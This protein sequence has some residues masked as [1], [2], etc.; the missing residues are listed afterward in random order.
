MSQEHLQILQ[1]PSRRHD[2]P[3]DPRQRQVACCGCGCAASPHVRPGLEAA[4]TAAHQSGRGAA[5]LH[6]SRAAGWSLPAPALLHRARQLIFWPASQM[7]AGSMRDTI[8]QVMPAET[9]CHGTWEFL[10][11][12]ADREAAPVQRSR[13]SISVSS[14]DSNLSTASWLPVPWEPSSLRPG[15]CMPRQCIEQYGECSHAMA[16]LSGRQRSS[17]PT[18]ILPQLACKSD[19]LNTG[20][21]MTCRQW[22]C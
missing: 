7:M 18:L 5:G 6:L 3:A 1:R 15:S 4:H 17:Q 13:P 19:W 14:T 22:Q 2:L 10:R 21:C 12:M 20:F 9:D 8:S 16:E 11:L